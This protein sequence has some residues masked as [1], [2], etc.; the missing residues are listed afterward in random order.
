MFIGDADTSASPILF[1]KGVLDKYYQV[2]FSN[3]STA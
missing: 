1:D 3:S 2:V